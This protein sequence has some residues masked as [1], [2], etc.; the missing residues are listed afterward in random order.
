M[1]SRANSQFNLHPKFITYFLKKKN[2]NSEICNITDKNNMCCNYWETNKFPN[3]E[4]PYLN[5]RIGETLTIQTSS[6]K[7]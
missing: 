5:L 1:A 6:T 7:D 3:G 2:C 4:N